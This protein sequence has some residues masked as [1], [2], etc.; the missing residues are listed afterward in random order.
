MSKIDDGGPA[1][2][3]PQS[4]DSWTNPETG[5]TSFQWPASSGMSLRDWFA[6]EALKTLMPEVTI[7]LH[8]GPDGQTFVEWGKNLDPRDPRPF[9]EIIGEIMS[10]TLREREEFIKTSLASAAYALADAMLR[11]RAKAT[12]PR[13]E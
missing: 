3:N 6:G 5:Y 8:Q 4:G 10:A 1:Y 2:P 9:K 7:N 13:K 11:E 12:E